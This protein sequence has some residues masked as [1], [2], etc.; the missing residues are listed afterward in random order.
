[1]KYWLAVSLALT[2]ITNASA[3][4]CDYVLPQRIELPYQEGKD[5]RV[6]FSRY[7]FNLPSKPDALLSGDG[8]IASYPDRGYIGQQHTDSQPWDD[9]VDGFISPTKNVADSYRLIYGVSSTNGLGI[10]EVKEVQR[11]RAL[12]KLDCNAKVTAYRVGDSVDVIFQAA[13]KESDFHTVWV[14]GD[15]GVD[16]ITLRRPI[17]EVQQVIASIKR[18]I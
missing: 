4:S 14:L 18:R 13:K 6:Y 2:G 1:M 3:E 8:F 11:Q 10:A 5:T 16:I 17:E 15:N 12:L 7:Q 9:Q